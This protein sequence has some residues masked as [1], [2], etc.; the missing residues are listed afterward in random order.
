MKSIFQDLPIA[1]IPNSNDVGLLEAVSRGDKSTT[2]GIHPF[3]KL[4]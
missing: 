2:L 3:T 4:V 1:G